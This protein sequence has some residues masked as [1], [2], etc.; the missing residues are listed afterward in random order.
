MVNDADEPYRVAVVDGLEIR[1]FDV[2]VPFAVL[3]DVEVPLL[4]GD[5]EFA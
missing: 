3:D 1:V 4:V 5:E 2:S